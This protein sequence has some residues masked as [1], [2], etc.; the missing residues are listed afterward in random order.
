MQAFEYSKPTTTKEALGMLGAQWGETD[1][2]AGGT[3]LLSLMKD[4]VHTPKRVVSLSGIKELK[5][6]KSA[7]DGLHIG[8]MVTIEE[9]LENAQVRKEYASLVQAARGISSPQIRAM[10]TVG[11][12]LCQRPRCWYF[13]KGFGLLPRDSRGRDLV[14]NGE[15]RYHA[16]LGN[17]GPAKFVSA[18]SLAPALVALGAKVTI[19]SASG[20]RTVDVEKFFMA[21]TDAS[22]REV[23]LKPNEILTGIVVPVAGGAK[24]A[25]YEVRQKEA[26]DWP[27]ATASVALKMSGS[28]VQSAKVV[29]GHVAPTPWNSAEAAQALAGKAINESTAKVAADAALARATP[30]SQNAYKVQLAKVAVKRALLAAAGKA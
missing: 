20:N 29:L 25:T 11:G 3:D 16:I 30:L 2:L 9:L 22:T 18:S 24:Q 12:D 27:L 7:A 8:A 15:N 17:S 10:G 28:T 23:D 1:I 26:L 6:I 4:Y 14:P 13:R 5:L 19:A 21:P